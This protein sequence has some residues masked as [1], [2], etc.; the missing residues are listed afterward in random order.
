MHFYASQHQNFINRAPVFH[1]NTAA[2]IRNTKNYF[3]NNQVRYHVVLMQNLSSNT[4]EKSILDF[5]N[6]I[7][8]GDKVR[9]FS[10]QFLTANSKSS[11]F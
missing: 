8:I 7:Q 5:C 9:V 1:R 11:I 2:P 6:N 3:V 4:N 10:F